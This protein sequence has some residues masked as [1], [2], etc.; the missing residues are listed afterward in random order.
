[1]MADKFPKLLDAI[2]GKVLQQA[3]SASGS[4]KPEARHCST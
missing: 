4:L 1:M 3:S 2:S